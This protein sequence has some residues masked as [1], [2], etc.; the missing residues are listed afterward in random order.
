[1]AGISTS[2]WRTASFLGSAFQSHF[3]SYILCLFLAESQ[4][5]SFWL[6]SVWLLPWF[7]LSFGSTVCPRPSYW[8]TNPPAIQYRPHPLSQEPTLRRVSLG[9]VL[10]TLYYLSCPFTTRMPTCNNA[11]IKRR[12]FPCG[13]PGS[14][15]RVASV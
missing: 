3:D 4:S 14:S 1:M 2:T 11:R 15:V 5:Y 7:S 8:F 13:V 6:Q 9:V 12:F 10:C